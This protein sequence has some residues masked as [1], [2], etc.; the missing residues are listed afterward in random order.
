MAEPLLCL[1][2]AEEEGHA[3]GD[4][5]DAPA[6]S[7]MMDGVDGFKKLRS[8]NAGAY[9]VLAFTARPLLSS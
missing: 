3:T 4:A 1:A 2:T 9:K 8:Q 5:T 6:V 7:W